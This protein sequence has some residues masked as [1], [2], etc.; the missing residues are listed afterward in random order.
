MMV[1]ELIGE[2]GTP[3]DDDQI[4]GV[5][6]GRGRGVPDDGSG[7]GDILGSPSD[8]SRIWGGL[9]REPSDRSRILGIPGGASSDDGRI[10]SDLD[11]VWTR[12]V[13]FD[14]GSDPGPILGVII[15]V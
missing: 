4:L 3:S 8:G 12:R 7:P 5:L 6:I 2:S 15:I 1:Q 10:W 14:D 9:M 13:C 11:V